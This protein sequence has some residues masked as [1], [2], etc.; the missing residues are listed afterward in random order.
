MII[1]LMGCRYLF[2]FDRGTIIVVYYGVYLIE[3]DHLYLLVSI[4]C[5]SHFFRKIGLFLF[6]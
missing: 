5:G 3:R 4:F 1:A 2:K 6:I